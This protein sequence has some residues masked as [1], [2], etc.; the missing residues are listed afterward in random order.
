M[1]KLPLSLSVFTGGVFMNDR[2]QECGSYKLHM[3]QGSKFRPM[4][5]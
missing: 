5:P 4:L 3:K 1:L 2:E